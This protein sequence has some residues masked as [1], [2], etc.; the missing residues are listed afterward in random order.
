[1]MCGGG[2]EKGMMGIKGKQKQAQG[3]DFHCVSL[4][5]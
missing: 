1:M 2:G 5:A 4:E 3:I